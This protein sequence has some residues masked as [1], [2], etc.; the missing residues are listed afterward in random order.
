MWKLGQRQRN[1][2]FSGN[3]SIGFSLQC[4]RMGTI[5]NQRVQGHLGGQ[6]GSWERGGGGEVSKLSLLAA[7]TLVV[8]RRVITLLLRVCLLQLFI[9]Q[10][11]V[12]S[13]PSTTEPCCMYVCT[14]TFVLNTLHAILY[15]AIIIR[16][17]F[18]P[19]I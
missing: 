15:T 18:L 17:T 14:I 9:I 8:T 13:P 12:L 6:R 1:S 4:R 3:T 7:L 16:T 11:S 5:G 10:S 19:L 2:F